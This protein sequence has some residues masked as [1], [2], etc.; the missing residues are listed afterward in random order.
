MLSS[1]DPAPDLLVGGRYRLIESLA[2]GGTASVWRAHDDQTDRDVAIKI[3]RDEGV[4]PALRERASQE[5]R[6]LEGLDH[7]NI[8]HVLDGGVDDGLPFMVMELLEGAPLNR[9]IA[10]R[11][12]IPVDEAVEL[13]ADVADGLGLAHQRGVVHRDVK[14]GNIVC[15]EK[16]P[17]LVDF[18]IARN[19]DATTLTR[20][21]V[22]GTAA[23]LAP[24]QA[25]GRTITPAADVYA[26]ACVL[27]E[28][29]TGRPP[30]D[31]DSPVTVALKHV[32]EEPAPPSDLGTDIPASVDA[33]VMRCLAKDPT[34]RP[35]DGTAL[36]AELRAALAG[37]T[38]DETIAIGAPVASD[39]TMVMPVIGA[40]TA[41]VATPDAELIDPSPLAAEPRTIRA[42]DGIRRGPT[43]PVGV[44][45]GLVVA[46]VLLAGLLL[47]SRGGVS[48]KIRTV[49][50]VTNA[51]VEDATTYLEGAGL[52]VDVTN[53]PSDAPAGTVIASTPAAGQKIADHGTVEIQV[54]SGPTATTTPPTTAAPAPTGGGGGHDGK[55]GQPHK[56]H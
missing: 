39:G 45:I 34:L 26:L 14:P 19:I 21:L 51:S 29:L 37:D 9:I 48:D 16:V 47:A 35:A 55:A 23:Y 1:I 54:S 49:P 8:V 33:V 30:F 56:G 18:G 40:A 27:Y 15:H 42:R 28:L 53:V 3:L 52:E 11:G 32:Q 7:P 25:Q 2:R 6:I 43:M 4:D 17:T 36:A 12:A 41:A 5:A 24:E 31:G 38:G 22:V 20:G 44:I 46:A 10:E 13:V 50:D